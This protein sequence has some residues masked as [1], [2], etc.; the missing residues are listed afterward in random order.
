MFTRRGVDGGHTQDT[1]AEEGWPHP[2]FRA[3][4]P[5][6]TPAEGSAPLHL[7][8]ELQQPARS[9]LLTPAQLCCEELVAQ[10]CLLLTCTIYKIRL[11]IDIHL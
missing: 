4:S 9:P 7:P 3:G 8:V 10:T 2:H 1:Q 11:K 6:A 5:K